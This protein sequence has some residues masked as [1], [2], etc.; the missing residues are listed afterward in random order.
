MAKLKVVV[1]RRW[2]EGRFRFFGW[3]LLLTDTLEY[4][5]PGESA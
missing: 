5:A 4:Q 2:Y 3:W 1:M